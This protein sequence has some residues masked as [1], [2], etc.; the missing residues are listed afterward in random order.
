MPLISNVPPTKTF[1]MMS[2]SARGYKTIEDTF[3]ELGLGVGKI[4]A[5][6]IAEF[7]R[8]SFLRSDNFGHSKDA[9]CKLK[10]PN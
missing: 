10:R 3:A 7:C 5:D 6:I 4:D 2:R 9:S 8:L 1:V